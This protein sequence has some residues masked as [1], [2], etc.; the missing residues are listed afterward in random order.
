VQ[1][2]TKKPNE[3]AVVVPC[4]NVAS[5]VQRALDS[6][7]AQTYKDLQVYAVDD[8]STDDTMHVLQANAGRCRIVGQAHAGPGAARNR[9]I[10]LS[11]SP[12]IA[13]LDADDEWLPEKLERQIS[14]LRED[15][16]LGLVC[17]LC[18]VE[19]VGNNAQL[20][21]QARSTP[22]SGRLFT[23]LALNCFVFTPTVVVRRCCLEEVGLFNESLAVSEDFNL[24]LRIAAR[25]KIALLPEVLA[26]NH[27]RADSLSASIAA[28]ER[29]RTGVAALE[30]VQSSCPELLPSEGRAL[31]RALAERIYFYGSFLLA[32]GSTG[33][34][35]RKLESVLKLQPTHWRAMAKLALSFLPT[36]AH[37]LL[38]GLRSGNASPF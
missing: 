19:K 1:S 7:F 23:Q 18:A 27:R 37:A 6:A 2:R 35:R 29:L 10:E 11:D 33:L 30:H 8:G 25:W 38:A 24:W 22:L 17:S 16:S 3:V 21:F 15:T 31:R 5:C 28:E 12:F 9:A 4:Y 34:A 14:L 32:T 20:E 13:F 26:I 36:P